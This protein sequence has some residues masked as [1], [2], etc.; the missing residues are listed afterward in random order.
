MATQEDEPD[1]AAFLKPL[2]ADIR[3]GRHVQDLPEDLVRAMQ[4]SAGSGVSLDED[5]DGSVVV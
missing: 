1:V 3:A 4:T 5:I 2:E